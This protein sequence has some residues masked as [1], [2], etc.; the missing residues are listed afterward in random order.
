MK[1]KILRNKIIIGLTALLLLLVSGCNDYLELEPLD[2]VSADQLL[3]NENGLKTLLANLYNAIPME[4]FNYRPN[5]GFN[6][7]GIGDGRIGMTSMFSDEA[8]RSDGQEAIGP[9]GER[10]NY[11]EYAYQR[12]RDVSLFLEGIEKAKNDLVIDMETYNCLESEA[13]FI[14]A[15]LYFGLVKRFGGVPI[16]GKALDG[17]Y[18]PGSDNAALYIPRSTE[19]DTWDFILKE[20]DKAITNLPAT[21]SDGKFRAD[22][23]TAYALK[24]RVALYAASLAKYWNNAP[25][26]G[27]AVTLGYVGIS[28]NEA[29]YF[30]NE[31]IT[32]SKEIIDN[33]GHTLYMP[34]PSSPAEAAVNYQNLFLTSNNEII[35]SKTYLDGSLV[36]NQGHSFD[37]FYSPSQVHPGYLRHGRYSPTLDIVDLYEDYTDDGNGKS[38]KII[39]R[40]DGVEDYY[41]GNPSNIDINTPFRKYSDLSEPFIGKDARLQTSI[42]VPGA[43][44]KDVKIIIQGGLIGKNGDVIAYGAG[45]E[46]GYD[47]KTYYTYGAASP[48]GYSGFDNLGRGFENSNFS[49]SGFT[50]RKY[51]AENKNLLVGSGTAVST[52]PWIDMRLA[53]VY[54]NYA[55]AVVESGQGDATAAKNY[56]NQLRKRAGHTDEIPLTLSNVLKERRVELAFEGFRYDDMFRRR[57]Y[58]IFFNVGRRHALVPLIDLREQ[59]PKY[60]FIR[61]NLYYDE[62]LGGRT[63]N[64]VDYYLAIPS[65][66]TNRLVQNPGH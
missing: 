51:L 4:D 16:I 60:I 37:A 10:F 25:L 1:N 3:T 39:T 2:K 30:Y 35:F 57:E 22:K 8:I 61:A 56:L 15:Y 48:T 64:P 59:D 18:V 63:F 14:R 47:G 32:A 45:S 31:C 20:C 65:T 62:Q 9:P 54:L 53:E 21:L 42:I 33:S 41:I 11:F 38:A 29:N 58:H 44:F 19:R 40:T 66:Q 13:H 24:S 34:N 55:E 12:N 6:N 49:C 43:M 26:T 17:E 52:T 27:E 50:I 46:E 28:P 36:S 7:R 23:W 5:E